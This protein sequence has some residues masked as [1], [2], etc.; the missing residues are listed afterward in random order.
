MKT[1][2]ATKQPQHLAKK[3]NQRMHL[4]YQIN[5]ESLSVSQDIMLRNYLWC[6]DPKAKKWSNR[7]RA[8]T[9]TLRTQIAVQFL[10]EGETVNKNT[11][12][13][14]HHQIGLLE[15]ATFSIQFSPILFMVAQWTYLENRSDFKRTTAGEWSLSFSVALVTRNV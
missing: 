3:M 1:P 8:H 6:L 5:S 4:I 9:S 2:D 12:I 11:G 13:D 10:R 7:S 14:H 15:W